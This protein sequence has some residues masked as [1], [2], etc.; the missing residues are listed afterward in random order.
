MKRLNK[1]QRE[2]V[3]SGKNLKQ[4]FQK[5]EWKK[6]RKFKKRTEKEKNSAMMKT[7]RLHSSFQA[8]KYFFTSSHQSY[9]RKIFLVFAI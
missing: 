4:E 6:T 8:E 5:R 9:V 1:K 3:N 2:C 7:F